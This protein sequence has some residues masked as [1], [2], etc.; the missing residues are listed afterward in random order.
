[1][2]ARLNNARAATLATSAT[3]FMLGVTFEP[4]RIDYRHRNRRSERT[5]VART[6]YR[7]KCGRYWDRTS[8]LFRVK[9]ARY[10]CANR[11]EASTI[12]AGAGRSPSHEVTLARRRR[13]Q[14]NVCLL[15]EN[16]GEL[17]EQR[18]A[19]HVKT[20]ERDDM[21]HVAG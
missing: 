13:V 5:A 1:M 21:L 8:D 7:R 15:L 2:T 10:P 9:E 6:E 3:R 11:P 4:F 19:S 17:R 16:G 20:V 18:A 12:L 14:V